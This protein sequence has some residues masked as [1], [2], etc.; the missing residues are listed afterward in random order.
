MCPGCDRKIT[1]YYPIRD[2]DNLYYE[3]H[4]LN[5]YEYTSPGDRGDRCVNSGSPVKKAIT[6]PTIEIP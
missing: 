4:F 1:I 2:P 3:K 6:V 5:P